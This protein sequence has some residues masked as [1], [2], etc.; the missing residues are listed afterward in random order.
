MLSQI[1]I[2]IWVE[3]TAILQDCQ[4]ALAGD[5]YQLQIC[6]SGDLL[7]DYAQTHRDQI[8]CL[9]LVATNPGCKTVIQQLCFQGIVVPAIV[10]GDRDTDD[11]TDTQKDW[12]YHSAELHLGIH[13]LEQLPYQVDAALAEFLRQ[14]PVETIADQVMLMAATHDPE[15]ASHQRDLAQRLQERLGYLGVYYKRDPDR[16]LRN[17]PALRGTEVTRGDADQLSRDCAELF[18]PQ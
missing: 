2:C 15:L 6:S 3:S 16:F 5:R 1:A 17:L 18:L 12:V 14:A 7:L 9:L 8:D 4:Q 13:Q 11:V 10:V